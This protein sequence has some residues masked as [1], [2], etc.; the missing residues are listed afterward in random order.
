MRRS[1]IL[2]A[3]AFLLALPASAE[4]RFRVVLDPGHGGQAMGALGAYGVYEKNVTLAIAKRVGRLLEAVPGFT[5]FYTRNDD[6]YVDLKDRS[7]MANDLEADLFVSIHCNASEATEAH[8]IETF[9]LGN[10][11]SDPEADDVA[12]RENDGVSV[13]A[14]EDDPALAQILADLRHTGNQAESAAVADTVQGRLVRAFPEAASRDVRQARFAVLR[15]AKMPALVIEVGFLTHAQEGLNLILV[16]Y[17][18]R[19][20][21][22]IR[23]AIVAWSRDHLTAGRVPPGAEKRKPTARKM[24]F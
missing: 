13:P 3:L 23:D 11:G 8:G 1:W 20:A 21:I 7:A 4:A 15:R 9:Y 19:L 12:R 24:Q 17:Q 18:E 10:E 2:A 5:V 22:A 14:I 16:P 6:V